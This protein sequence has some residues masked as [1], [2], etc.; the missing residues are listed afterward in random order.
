VDNAGCPRWCLWT[1]RV[2]QAGRSE[3]VVQLLTTG[4]AIARGRDERQLPPR[5]EA[6]AAAT[7]EERGDCGRYSKS[8]ALIGGSY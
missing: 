7:T 8:A 6:I 4:D 3:A 1:R 2:G 5:D